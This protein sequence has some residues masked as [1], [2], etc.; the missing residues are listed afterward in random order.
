MWRPRRHILQILRTGKVRCVHMTASEAFVETLASHKVT[1]TFGIV[2]S[3]FMDPL[4]SFG[5]AGIRFISVQHEQNAAHMAD[6]YA[7]ISG[8]HGV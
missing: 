1:N 6:G 5:T 3:A 4:H 7:R 2:G 8:N